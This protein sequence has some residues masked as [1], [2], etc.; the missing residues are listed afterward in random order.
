[1]IVFLLPGLFFENAAISILGGI[2]YVFLFKIP[3]TFITKRLGSKLIQFSIVLLGASLDFNSVV[4][5]GFDYLIVISLFVV[6]VL[7]LALILGKVVKVPLKQS[8]M[9]AAGSAICGATAIATISSVIKASSKEVSIAI[10]LVFILNLLAILTFPFMGHVME[11]TQS[12]FGL[13]TVLAIHDTSSVLGAASQYGREAI[14]LA[15]ILK[16][17][18]TLWLV[19]LVIFASYYFNG[20]SKITGF[21]IFIIFFL[22]AIGLNYFINFPLSLTGFISQSS[23]YLLL[24]GL[25][26]I[27]TQLDKASLGMLDNRSI[28]QAT[29]LWTVVVP[30]SLMLVLFF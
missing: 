22:M 16:I 25:F 23:S 5:Y 29:L 1:M 15:A 7:F 2:T 9:I 3:D 8:F 30:V 10:G 21:P 28:L 20:E 11:L 18:K 26:C 24:I 19:P 12:Q 14:E 6:G 4:T 27:G 13:W 17:A